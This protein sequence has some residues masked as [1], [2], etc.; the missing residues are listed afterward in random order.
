MITLNTLNKMFLQK[1]ITYVHDT[2]FGPPAVR[3]ALRALRKHAYSK[4]TENFT[5]KN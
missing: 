3:K 5:S 4:Y 1:K 2:T